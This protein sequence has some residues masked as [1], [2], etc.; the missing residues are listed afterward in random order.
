MS[1]ANTPQRR[2]DS[3]AYEHTLAVELPEQSVADRIKEVRSACETR[4]DFA[5]TVL[6][7]AFRTQLE[8]PSGQV[9]MRLAPTAIEPMVEISARG[10]RIISRNTHAEDL[11]E[12]IADTDRQLALLSSHRD[13]LDEFLQR[14]DLKVEQV[15]EL[16]KEVSSSQTQIDAL[17]AQRANLQRR[18]DTELLT[19]EL[20][21]PIGTEATRQTPLADAVRSFGSDLREAIA[22]VIRFIA[23]LLPW[24]IV[25]VPGIVLLRLFWRWITR[26]L[27][28]R[29]PGRSGRL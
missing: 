13:R 12:P 17:R 26:W 6:D 1:E 2:A 5:C 29:E 10:G 25:I 11:A 7:V 9:R 3:L 21:P 27:A 28:R 19:I 23:F 24:L 22:Q 14:K 18:I 15:I 20:S 16:S 8:V 4:K